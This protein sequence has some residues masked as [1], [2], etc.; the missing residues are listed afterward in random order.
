[1]LNIGPRTSGTTIVH[2]DPA[3]IRESGLQMKMLERQKAK[4]DETDHYGMH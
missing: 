2:R 1:M 3:R 4:L